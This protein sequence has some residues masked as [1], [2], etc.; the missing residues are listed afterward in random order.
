[1]LTIF[2]TP[3]PFQGHIGI[4][5]RNAIQSWMRVHPDVEIILFGDEEGTAETACEFGLRHVPNVPRNE[6][7][8]K[9]LRGFFEP[10]QQMA[11][12]ELLC[13]INCDIMILPTFSAA[14]ERA[15]SSFP[16][17]LMVGQ[18]WN[19]DITE[20]WDFRDPNWNQQLEALVKNRG[21]LAGPLGID[22]FVFRRGLYRNMPPLVI[23]RIWWDH[24]LIWRARSLRIPVVDATA[25]VK[26]VHQNHDYSYHP[27]GAA[28]VWQ[29][30][31]ARE[32]YELAGGKWHL[33]TIE[34]ATHRLTPA[35]VE[36]RLLYPFAPFRRASRPYLAPVWYRLL[37]LTR[38]VRHLVGIRRRARGWLS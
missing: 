1:M 6:F 11:R 30:R 36:R 28:G 13:Y 16:R 4:I 8:T 34:D 24:W 3:K 27:A 37:D 31:Q 22:Y 25:F 38:P 2:S 35:G 18:R 19:T 26:A 33:Y 12:H 29:D 10:A 7:G 32:N 5:Q 15:A 20:P 21:L 14:I 17:F 23:G 9:L